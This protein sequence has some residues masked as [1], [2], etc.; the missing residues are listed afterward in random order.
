MSRGGGSVSPDV[1]GKR[2][3]GVWRGCLEVGRVGSGF[4]GCFDR[5]VGVSSKDYYRI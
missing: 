1:F 3:F 5:C 2:S 4:C